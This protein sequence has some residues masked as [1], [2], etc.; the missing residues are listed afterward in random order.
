MIS[1]ESSVGSFHIS[2]NGK[3]AK[4]VSTHLK[5][6]CSD[7]GDHFTRG[8]GQKEATRPVDMVQ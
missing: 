3:S 2:T 5:W 4:R 7:R 1:I 6:R 8:E